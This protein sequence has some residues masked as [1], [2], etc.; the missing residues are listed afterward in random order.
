MSYDAF[1][2]APGLQN[3]MANVSSISNDTTKIISGIMDI[4]KDFEVIIFNPE[5]T[6]I[7]NGH[8]LPAGA[9]AVPALRK[10]GCKLA[11]FSDDGR[12]I[13][14]ELNHLGFS[15]APERIFNAENFLLIF[16]TFPLSQPERILFVTGDKFMDL[17]LAHSHGLKTL[18]IGTLDEKDHD[19]GTLDPHYHATSL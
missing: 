13:T 5:N 15:F 19:I 8:T 18:L 10:T 1:L 3:K 12:D 4:A 17:S 7:N 14:G 16:E 11:A 9:V 6:L 2:D